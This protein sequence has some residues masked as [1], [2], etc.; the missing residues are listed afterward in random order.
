M[1]YVI[2]DD[3]IIFNDNF[4]KIL[5]NK[6]IND[7]KK[8]KNVYFGKYFNQNIDNL[9]DN[10]KIIRF[11]KKDVWNLRGCY[12]DKPIDNLPCHL[13]EL[14]LGSE[15]NQNLDFLPY[16]L[17]KLHLDRCYEKPLNNLPRSIVELEIGEYYKFPIQHLQVKKLIVPADYLKIPYAERIP[18]ILIKNFDE[19]CANKNKIFDLFPELP[20]NIEKLGIVIHRYG[21]RKIIT[22]DIKN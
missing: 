1:D 21:K 20:R 15:F 17:K 3:C 9:P 7:I 18:L 6:I 14:Y 10:V 8:V 5:D 11:G 22:I 13:E 16:S 19:I 2:N 4:N 12:F